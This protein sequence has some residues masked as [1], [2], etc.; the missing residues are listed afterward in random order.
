MNIKKHFIISL[1]VLF[2]IVYIYSNHFSKIKLPN[3][4]KTLV[5]NKNDH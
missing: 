5:D 4:T 2:I 3:L 1:L